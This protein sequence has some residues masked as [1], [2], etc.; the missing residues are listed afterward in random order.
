MFPKVFLAN[1]C[2]NSRGIISSEYLNEGFRD[3]YL[4]FYLH[5]F[6]ETIQYTR[7]FPY[8]CVSLKSILQPRYDIIMGHEITHPK[9]IYTDYI[10]YYSLLVF[11]RKNEYYFKDH[12]KEQLNH[13][14]FLSAPFQ[15][16]YISYLALCISIIERVFEFVIELLIGQQLGS[17]SQFKRECL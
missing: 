12:L 13:L 10:L 4:G 7:Y 11:Q 16:S 6:M 9:P 8:T 2:A 1:F 5:S 17:I 15:D 3:N 14:P